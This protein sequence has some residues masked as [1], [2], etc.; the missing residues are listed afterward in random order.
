MNAQSGKSGSERVR[1]PSRRVNRPAPEG[2]DLTPQKGA[3]V[4]RA[5]EDNDQSWGDRDEGND[6]ELRLNKPPHWG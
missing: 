1:R 4:V 5:S 3:P 2:T 6:G